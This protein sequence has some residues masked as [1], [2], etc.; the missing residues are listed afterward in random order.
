MRSPRRANRG[1]R[2]SKHHPEEQLQQ[3][4]RDAQGGTQL[5]FRL[6]G[7]IPRLARDGAAP[8]RATLDTLILEPGEGRVTLVHRA[9]FPVDP[10]LETPDLTLTLPTHS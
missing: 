5:R 1:W 2:L 7:L 8:L 9:L 6:P 10:G 4:G 3:A